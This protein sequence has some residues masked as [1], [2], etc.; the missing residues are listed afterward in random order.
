MSVTPR[1]W[2]FEL[3]LGARMSV[4]GGG[5]GWVRLSLIAAGVG[6]GVAVLLGAAT[7]PAALG[8]SNAR[9]DTRVI[10]TSHDLPAADDTLLTGHV[11][12]T[13]EGTSI[14]G[15]LLR[16]EGSHPPLPP[17]VSRLPGP[18][19]MVASPALARMLAEPGS[20]LLRERWDAEV[21]GVIGAE[22]LSGPAELFF[23]LGTDK[24]SPPGAGRIDEFGT[25]GAHEAVPMAVL[26]ILAGMVVLL[27]PVL[28]FM[29]GA[30]RFG[31]RTRNRRLA[32]LRLAG[33]DI[34]MTRRIAAGETLI[35]A[36]LGLLVGG[37]L[38]AGG[39]LLAH[40][41]GTGP[42]SFYPADLRP[43]PLLAAAIV[44]A[45]PVAAVLVTL[46]AM[47]RVV[48]EPLGVTRMSTPTRRR[49][50]WRLLPSALGIVLLWPLFEGGS[51]GVEFQIAGGMALLLIGVALLLPW[52][53]EAVVDRLR[54]G[55]PAWELAVRRLQLD[56]G[57][58]VRAV[59]GIAV[60]VAGVLAMQGL[61]TGIESQV[62]EPSTTA[63]VRYDAEIFP[64]TTLPTGVWARALAATPGV[65]E[66]TEGRHLSVALDPGDPVAMEQLRNTA[67]GLDPQAY[68]WTTNNDAARNA[69]AGL[70]DTLLAGTT[71]LLLLIGASMIINIAEQLR[72]RRRALAVLAAFGTPHR[73][74]RASI[75]YQVTVPVA[76]GMLLAIT[77]GTGLAA[78]LQLA[79]SAPLRVD[80]LGIGTTSGIGVLVVLGTTAAGLPLLRSL[81]SPGNLR[82]E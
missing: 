16:P 48:A 50:W 36:L 43:V 63:A 10:E 6:L 12:T 46:T 69:L 75:L 26:L 76:L 62:T 56:S 41:Y 18:G 79:V 8:A 59:S 17:G 67:A 24:L 40:R 66:V 54:G 70:R 19:Q 20:G 77:V 60:S 80:W 3:A 51:S 7:V 37:L 73:T 23:Y 32:A 13:Y 1:R 5:A 29:A 74:L 11:T 52:L 42:L 47:R 30:V 82:T 9:I 39:I 21:V 71:A 53:V 44:V 15:E 4:A 22:G 49:F 65:R 33:S 31:D 34:A 57:T 2:L 64:E 58:A 28:V 38:W 35:G 78:M 61:V 81:T 72:E 27:I 68:V 14:S 25:S 55:S 45:V